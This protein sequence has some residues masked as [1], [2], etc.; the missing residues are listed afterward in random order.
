MEV[1]RSRE[2]WGVPGNGAVAVWARGEAPGA[3]VRVKPRPPP[4][5]RLALLRL[6]KDAMGLV[7]RE[8]TF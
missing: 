1:G 8:H 7:P 3:R 5:P 4:T 2:E 6:E